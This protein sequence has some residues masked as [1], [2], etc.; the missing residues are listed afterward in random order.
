MT[1]V[2]VQSLVT[3]LAATQHVL[4]ELRRGWPENSLY[5]ERTRAEWFSHSKY[6]EHLAFCS[7]YRGLWGLVIV[8]LSWLSA[9]HWRLKPEVSW[10]W[11]PVTA[12][13]FTFLY[14]HL[15]TS[16]FIYFQ[17]EARCSEHLEW[18]NYSA[19]VLSWRR[20]FS[21]PPLMEFWWHVLSGCQ[22]CDQGIQYHLCDI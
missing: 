11:L 6:S 13:L 1:F 7:T 14:F 10:V 12:G 19:W 9:G 15:I 4:S 5:Q 21:G 2:N 20:E 3:H 8:R 22:V 18:E 16:K 17:P